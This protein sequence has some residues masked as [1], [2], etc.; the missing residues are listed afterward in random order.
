MD[1][2]TAF[3]AGVLVGHW[4]LLFAIWR[5]VTKLIKLIDTLE[6]ER[7]ATSSGTNSRTVELLEDRSGYE[8]G[9]YK[10]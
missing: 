7:E 4:I 3:L 2:Y 8:K 6:A 1:I 5:A 9:R 10:W